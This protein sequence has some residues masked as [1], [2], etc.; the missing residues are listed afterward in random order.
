MA[1][2]YE[3]LQGGELGCESLLFAQVPGVRGGIR[4]R[5]SG[6]TPASILLVLQSSV[7]PRN[8]D[9]LTSPVSGTDGLPRGVDLVVGQ[10]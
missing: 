1:T 5:L 7:C 9:D 10:T 4:G 6:V 3:V 8:L 2:L